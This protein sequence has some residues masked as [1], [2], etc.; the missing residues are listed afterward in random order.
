MAKDD[1]LSRILK[2]AISKGTSSVLDDIFEEI[3]VPLTTF[4]QD[5]KYLGFQPLSLVQ[6]QA[7]QHIERIYF[8]GWNMVGGV[9]KYDP[10]KDTYAQLAKHEPYWA[11]PIRMANRIN[12]M[13]GKGAGK[14]M[15][16]RV[17]TARV[18]YLL[19]CL[20]HPSMY[21]G[22]QPDDPIHL[23]NVAVN[24]SQA[25]T[26]FYQPFRTMMKKGWFKDKCN[27]T[28]NS[29]TFP[30]GIESI[31]GH[32]EAD[33]QEGM[34]LLLGIA[35]EIDGFPSLA[36][37]K[38]NNTGRAPTNTAEGILRMMYTSGSTRFPTYKTV[39]ISYPRYLGSMIM[40]LVE[41]GRQDNAKYGE[42]SNYY[43]S[44]P[45]STWEVNPTVPGPPDLSKDMLKD[46][47]DNLEMAQGMYE[48]KPSRAISPYFRNVQALDSMWVETDKPPLEVVDYNLI[49]KSWTPVYEFSDDFKPIE[50]ARYAM[51]GDMAVVGDRAA[52]SMSHVVRERDYDYTILDEEGLP[53]VVREMRPIIK[54]DF[55]I[56]YEAD[57]S[58]N[59]ERPS[60]EIQIR[61]AREL[62]AQLRRRGFDIR[63]FTFDG[64]QS[65]DSMQ[66]LDASGIESKRVSTDISDVVWQ[67]L[68][69]V[70]H[71]GRIMAPRN[72]LLRDELLALSRNHKNKIDHPP[73]GSKDL[74]DAFACSI[75]GAMAVGGRESEDGK[76]A[77]FHEPEFYVGPNELEMP[78]GMENINIGFH[79]MG[80][81]AYDSWDFF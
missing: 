37:R 56:Y 25:S 3:P 19:L 21:F 35:D 10:S 47:E 51:H 14:D 7:V 53:F 17:A 68:T 78:I 34:N 50:G 27:P 57:I 45:L 52:V 23:L 69:D 28:L 44:G 60:R 9:N 32:S 77:F 42:E 36:E 72:E 74:A 67:S 66:Q 12:L 6:Y 1:E 39:A 71:D 79:E 40:T 46:Y 43:V 55:V 31:S 5:K 38:M 29:T 62:S 16:V 73:N 20:K 59:E 81:Q 64:F 13:W 33:S 76:V 8:N 80:I 18:V 58:S 49:G 63:L 61:W 30:K 26:A 15:T 48:C 11:E 4:V 54:N 24:A 41:A 70:I 65:V 22:K 75:V 2:E